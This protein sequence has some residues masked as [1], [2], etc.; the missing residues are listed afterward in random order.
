MTEVLWICTTGVHPVGI[1]KK[2]DE[3]EECW[4]FYIGTCRGYDLDEDVQQII[5]FGQK[6]YSLDFIA[7]FAKTAGGEQHDG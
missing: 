1:V 3:I 7:E 6:F 4:K 2:Y 5:D